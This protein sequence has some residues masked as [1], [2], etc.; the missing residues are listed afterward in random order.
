MADFFYTYIQ[1]AS[2]TTDSQGYATVTHG[3]GSNAQVAL[4][5]PVYTPSDGGYT[6]GLVPDDSTTDELTIRAITHY[7]SPY[8]NAEIQFCY[9][10]FFGQAVP[11]IYPYALVYPT[12]NFREFE[13]KGD[14]TSGGSGTLT[15][16]WAFGDG[17]RQTGQNVSHEYASAGVYVVTLVVHDS[18]GYHAYDIT[19]VEV[20]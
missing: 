16:H 11:R 1:K 19:S 14:S 15:Y 6:I 2:V 8:A 13:F 20:S 18:A 4:M 5:S 17:D 9:L 10:V 12:E 3:L 7:G